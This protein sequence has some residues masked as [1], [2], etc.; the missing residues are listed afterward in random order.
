MRRGGYH[1]WG[2]MRVVRPPGSRT[3]AAD[4]EVKVMVKA[5]SS[6]AAAGARQAQVTHCPPRYRSSV[7]VKTTV[8]PWRA[9]GPAAW[10]HTGLPSAP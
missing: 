1:P 8:S 6:P 7:P 4:A 9:S 3:S 5:P 10:Y 2:T